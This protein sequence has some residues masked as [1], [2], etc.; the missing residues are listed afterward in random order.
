MENESYSDYSALIE[1]MRYL[2]SRFDGEQFEEVR[3]PEQTLT[4][5][6]A[7]AY[8]TKHG[9]D[10]DF[11]QLCLHHKKNKKNDVVFSNLALLLSDQCHHAVCFVEYDDPSNTS[12][13]NRKEFDGSVL[14]QLEDGFS[15]LRQ[16]DQ[17]CNF[18]EEA[19]HEAL[20]NALVH[21]DYSMSGSILINANDQRI[22]FVS[23]GGLCPK[24]TVEDIRNGISQPRNPKLAFVFQHLNLMEAC[25]TGIRRILRSY[26]GQLVQ[27]QCIATANTFKLILP[28]T[29]AVPLDQTATAQEQCVLDYIS[30]NG[31][32]TDEIV[33]ELLQ[34]KTA[35]TYALMKTMKQKG[36]VLAQGRGS[37]KRYVIP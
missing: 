22:E 5:D 1:K 16:W 36:L 33:Q 23:I 27:P 26:E 21:R 35:R 2:V 13:K 30:Q 7:H 15:Y 3:S 25:G 6:T 11:E 34:I 8:F 10:L 24:L 9:S 17:K 37:E 12:V 19:L 29:N 20:V 18:P 31:Y 28:N 14:R 4:F 32:I